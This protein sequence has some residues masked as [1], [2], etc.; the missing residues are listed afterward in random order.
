MTWYDFLLEVLRLRGFSPCWQSW[1]KLWLSIT[2]VR[3]LVNGKVGKEMVCKRR[4]WQ[5]D[6]PFLLVY[7]M[8]ADE[9]NRMIRKA[10]TAS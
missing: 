8:I 6:L 5:H 4:L 10:E 9:F 7:V 1:I 2:K 3:V